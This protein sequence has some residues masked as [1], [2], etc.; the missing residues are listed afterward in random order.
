MDQWPSDLA[1][2]YTNYILLASGQL[3]ATLSCVPYCFSVPS[4][5]PI[6]GSVTASSDHQLWSTVGGVGG[7]AG[8]EF[9]LNFTEMLV[10]LSPM[11]FVNDMVSKLS[12]GA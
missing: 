2:Y 10:P 11:P 5:V 8:W 3:S 7:V 1:T 12:C 4:T 9:S 6:P